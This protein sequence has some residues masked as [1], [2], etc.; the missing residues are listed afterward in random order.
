MVVIGNAADVVEQKR[1][2]FLN[3]YFDEIL[4]IN[5]TIFNLESHKDYIGTPTLW[6]CCGWDSTKEEDKIFDPT[7]QDKEGI[8]NILKHS[9]IKK[10]L[11]N[12]TLNKDL[13]LLKKIPANIVIES[14]T[15]YKLANYSYH[16]AGLQSI[17]YGIAQGYKVYYLG[18]DSYR[19]SHH[20]YTETMP[21]NVFLTLHTQSNYIKENYEIKKLIKDRKLT[22]I[23]TIC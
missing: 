20:Y 15:D 9:N 3:D 10:A 6:C 16:S 4:I 12:C 17:L 21:E 8:Y 5:K 11:F 22:H 2:S 18:I 23:D 14:I 1:G 19:K 13:N 7:E